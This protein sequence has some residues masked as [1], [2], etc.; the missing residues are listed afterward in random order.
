M[1]NLDAIDEI[2]ELL[3]Q[4]DDEYFNTGESSLTD[5]EYD[6]LKRR[7]FIAEPHNEFFTKVGS[8][9][10]GGKIKL[11]Y[12]MGSLNQIYEGEATAWVSKY[13]DDVVIT[14]KLD[15]VSCMLVYRNG[16]FTIAYSRGDGIEGADISR[17]I[18]HT[19]IPMKVKQNYLV[20]RA[21]II[22]ANSVFADK[23]A[24]NKKNPRNMV[25]G[26][27]NRK[28]S[29]LSALTDVSVI[30]YEI[31]DSDNGSHKLPK[32]DM[33]G[34][35]TLPE[36]GFT[37][38]NYTTES[39]KTITDAWL[40]SELERRRAASDYE[41]DG[42]VLTINDHTKVDGS[43]TS[44]LNPEH[45]VKYKVLP[46]DAIVEAIVRDVHWKISKSGYINPRIEIFPVELFGTTVTFAT[47]FNAAYIASN[48]IG[49]GAKIQITKAGMVIPYVVRTIEAATPIMPPE[50]M[51]AWEYS[52]TGV[53]AVIVDKT[54]PN[55]IFE[56]VLDFF[57]TYKIDLLKEAT[58][59]KVAQA[60]PFTSY[61][62]AII[63]ICDL[64]ESEW[65]NVVGANGSKIYSSLKNR[66]A[67]SSYETFLGAITHMGIGFGVRKAKALLV[68]IL[69]ISEIFS[70]SMDDIIK[71]DGFDVKT[72][73]NVI[74]GLQKTK[75]LMD[76]LISNNVLSFVTETKTN[77]LSS[78][79]VVMTGFR[80]NE[81]Q[82]NIE[83]K[84]GKVSS[85]VSSKTTHLLCND[86]NSSS[87]KMKKARDSGVEIM[88]PEQFKMLHGL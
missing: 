18:K 11:P 58:L 30:A 12:T 48:G 16:N 64:T 2:I 79:N 37:V 44:S 76:K 36:N 54:N 39:P 28:D 60:F 22:M 46:E 72:A 29:D 6:T 32:R 7:A 71:K 52:E 26:L 65:V 8:D 43:T 24:D 21:E 1:L 45:S 40:T 83:S 9:I 50:S 53:E 17:H 19:N 4:C 27:V 56:Q 80:D 85:G 75:T 67:N 62:D 74:N 70:L 73:T 78:V 13:Q 88:T 81:L 31:V 20:V 33:F 38:V 82:G 68:N 5:K 25:A 86:P 59:V 34:L 41:L 57:E 51:G 63:N 47:G 14:D 87:S 23:Y 61:D 77:E 15:G 55:I 49:R 42:L 35:L 66:L 84:G 3:K 10:R 69:D